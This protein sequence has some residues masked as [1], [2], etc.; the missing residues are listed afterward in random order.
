MYL[1]VIFYSTGISYTTDMTTGHCTVSQIDAGTFDVNIPAY[2]NINAFT[3]Q[4][5]NP[6]QFFYLNSNLRY[7]GQVSNATDKLGCYIS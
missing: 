3:L 1:Y 4:L 6:L 5:K 7:A 2:N